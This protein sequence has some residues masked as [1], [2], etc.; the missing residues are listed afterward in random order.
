MIIG[1]YDSQGFSDLIVGSGSSQTEEVNQMIASGGE[2]GNPNPAGSEEHYEDYAS[3]Q[4]NS[5]IMQY[6]AYIVEGRTPH[7]DNS[8]ADFMDTSK[9]NRNN[10]YGWSW[11]SDMGPAFLDYVT[12]RNSS[13]QAS[14][15][16]FYN[17]SL[18]WEVLTAEINLGKPMVFWLTLMEMDQRTILS[19]LLGIEPVRL[20]S[21]QYGIHGQQLLFGGKIL[22]ILPL[23]LPGEFGEVGHSILKGKSA[24]IYSMLNQILQG[25]VVTGIT[26]VNFRQRFPLRNQEIKFGLQRALINP[27]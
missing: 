2:T 11:S 14:N 3:P 8:L 21:T 9:S 24:V 13:Y 16:F 6:D 1:Y 27:L 20:Y 25:I 7:T 26:P 12:S 18:T 19:R 15:N 5:P 22:S 23:E 17:N 4:D 10:Y